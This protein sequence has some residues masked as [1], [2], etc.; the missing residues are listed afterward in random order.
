MTQLSANNS[1]NHKKNEINIATIFDENRFLDKNRAITLKDTNDWEFLDFFFQMELRK[2]DDTYEPLSPHTLR[3]YKSDG[4]TLIEY[5]QLNQLSLKSIG[6][7]EVRHYCD[8]IKEKYAIR[9][10]I[11]KLDFFRR[12]LKFGADMHFYPVDFSGRV[13]KPK[14]IK[15]HFSSEDVQEQ[16]RGNKIA[17][18]R[19]LSERDARLII[20]SFGEIVKDT[21][22]NKS[23]MEFLKVRNSLIGWLLF[24]TGMRASEMISVTFDSFFE[25]DDTLHVEVLGKGRKPR[26]IPILS[27]NIYQL[28]QAHSSHIK[29]RYDLTERELRNVPLLFSPVGIKKAT[30]IKP[31]SYNNLYKVV[32]QAVDLAQKN[33]KISP[34]W[35]RH[36]YITTLLEKNV[37]LAV[38]KDN[39]GHSDIATTNMY[40]ETIENKSK[41]K[42][43]SHVNF[44]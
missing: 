25:E 17:K 37:P 6:D 14:A 5:L 1:N 2:N 24:G 20:E 28:F 23:F 15:G 21:T 35:F 31:M 4:K 11:R 27:N 19:E 8:Y 36:T 7:P 44:D 26:V 41:R 13:N 22:R 32:K 43:M 40:L 42:H 12:L 39:A 38:V 3:A 16:N 29:E 18:R 34:H 33:P 9:T 30:D 10:S